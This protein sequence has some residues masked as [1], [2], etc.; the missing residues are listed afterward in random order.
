LIRCWPPR[1]VREA[2]SAGPRGPARTGS[3]QGQRRDV[4]G[5][6]IERGV[7]PSRW[8]DTSPSS[9]TIGRRSRQGAG[10]ACRGS[11]GPARRRAW[12][13]AVRRRRSFVEHQRLRRHL[14]SWRTPAPGTDLADGAVH[15][16]HQHH[17]PSRAAEATRGSADV[18]VD[19]LAGRA[20]SS[21][22]ARPTS[23]AATA[24]CRSISFGHCH[25]VA[26]TI[27]SS[28]RHLSSWSRTRGTSMPARDRHRPAASPAADW[29]GPLLCR[30]R[31]GIPGAG[32]GKDDRVVLGIEV[33]QH[34]RRNRKEG[35]DSSGPS[36]PLGTPSRPSRQV[37]LT[38]KCEKRLAE[39]RGHGVGH[40]AVALA[41]GRPRR[42]PS[43]PAP[44]TR[45]A[46]GRGSAGTQRPRQLGGAALISV[47]K[48]GSPPARAGRRSAAWPGTAH[49]T[50]RTDRNGIAAQVG[51]LHLRQADVGHRDRRAGPPI[52]ATICDFPEARRPQ[53]ITGVWWPPGCCGTR[54]PGSS[55]DGQVAW[56][57]LES[58]MPSVLWWI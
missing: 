28:V 2:L 14:P 36:M 6:E 43:R 25:L 16:G 20:R 27:S 52:C 49:S 50:C 7:R 22:D 18:V 13:R 34:L 45:R 57:L 31:C 55:A 4:L 58:T 10:T 47:E 24:Y 42:S 30:P 17:G 41:V 23:A 51:R 46:G 19:L 29:D 3:R 35:D 33:E 38:S 11:A 48:T 12:S 37:G 54:G 32:E 40:A 39:R 8:S 21:A 53:S 5:V 15:V 56:G 26:P 9:R 1:E 44:G